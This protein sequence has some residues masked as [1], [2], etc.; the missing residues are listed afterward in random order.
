MVS[1][2]TRWTNTRIQS[3][4]RVN[5]YIKECHVKPGFD[6]GDD[7]G[8][9]FQELP[10]T[11]CLSYSVTLGKS[12][13]D[14]RRLPL[15]INLANLLSERFDKGGTKEDL[16]E[17]VTLKRDA[18]KY[19]SPDDPQGLAIYLELDRSLSQRFRSRGALVDLEEII[20]LRRVVSK[21]TPAQDQ[22]KPLLSIADSF[23]SQL[24]PPEHPDFA[25]SQ[26]RLACSFKAT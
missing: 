24:C 6:S 26:E 22:H 2:N 14:A 7:I 12:L 15:V 3:K 17:V 19:M 4:E 13:G 11:D 5:T 10:Y 25:F 16:D 9:A 8:N 21:S 1:W 20:S 18:P 23:T